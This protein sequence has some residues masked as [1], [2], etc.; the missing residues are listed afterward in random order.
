MGCDVA[1]RFIK[2]GRNIERA[3]M[4]TRII[5]DNSAVR[6]SNDPAPTAVTTERMWLSTL[7]AL[8]SLRMYRRHVGVHVHA[9][10]VVD[11]LLKDAHFSRTALHCL[12]ELEDCLSVLSEHKV[13]MK[14]C[15][16]CGG[17]SR[18]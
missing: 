16:T 7:N 11:Y 12:A 15:A 4:T 17:V 3:D 9:N 8:S 10:E 14:K 6:M 2:L 1:Y 13:P 5:D 18:R